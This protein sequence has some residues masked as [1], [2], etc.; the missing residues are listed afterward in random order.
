MAKKQAK[1]NSGPPKTGREKRLAAADK[2]AAGPSNDAPATKR[3]RGRPPKASSEG[4]LAPTPTV[5]TPAPKLRKAVGVT[6]LKGENASARKNVAAKTPRVTR[7]KRSRSF[8]SSSTNDTASEAPK[9]HRSNQVSRGRSRHSSRSR[10]SG[11]ARKTRGRRS[12][13]ASTE[14]SQPRKRR[15]RSRR[16][17]PSITS[18]S[19]PSLRSKRG[20]KRLHAHSHSSSRHGGRYRKSR[21]APN[22]RSSS[23]HGSRTRTG[24]RFKELK[25]K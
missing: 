12:S 25:K 23:A 11:R 7:R 13:S 10:H 9:R 21:K 2:N 4:P 5:A 14:A 20:K 1:A 24:K 19:T 15:T 3:P 16:H 17:V 22:S 6:Q 18:T 8:S